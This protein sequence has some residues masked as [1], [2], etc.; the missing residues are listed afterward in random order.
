[1]VTQDLC[2]TIVPYFKI[3]AGKIDAFKDLCR[4]LLILLRPSHYLCLYLGFSFNCDQA[5]CREGHRDA[6]GLLAHLDNV[7]L[8]GRDAESLISVQAQLDQLLSHSKGGILA[9]IVLLQAVD[10]IV[11]IFL[12]ASIV[13]AAQLNFCVATGRQVPMR[14]GLQ[15]FVI[16]CRWRGR[17][18]PSRQ[19]C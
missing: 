17:S 5:H 15:F 10:D 18:P 4:S 1:M 3:H 16:D 11:Q 19:A 9:V 14:G 13:I 6:G 7:S 8:D 12:Q 2:C